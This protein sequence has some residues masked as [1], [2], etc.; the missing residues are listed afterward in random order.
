MRTAAAASHDASCPGIVLAAALH[1]A[2]HG[3][4]FSTSLE[5]R[6]CAWYLAKIGFSSPYQNLQPGHIQSLNLSTTTFA[7][8]AGAPGFARVCRA[9]ASRNRLSSSA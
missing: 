2:F 5:S 1:L 6:G 7:P 4:S 3:Q 8:A 9:Q